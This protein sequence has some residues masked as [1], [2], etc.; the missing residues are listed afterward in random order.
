MAVYA[1]QVD[2][3][4]Q[5][6][7]RILA[8]VKAHGRY[9]NTLV[10]FLSDNGGCAE[11]LAEDGFV[12]ELLWPMRD[13][14]PV[15]AGNFQGVMPGGEDTYMSYD[16]PWANASNTPFRLFKHW[17]HEGGIATPMIASWPR[18]MPAERGRLFHGP[19]HVIDIMSTCIDA[20]GIPFPAEHRGKKTQPPEGESLLPVLSGEAWRRQTPLFWEHEGNCAIRADEWKL[21][22][23][24]PGDW[25]LYNVWEDRTELRDLRGKNRSLVAELEKQWNAWAERC[26]VLAWERIAHRLRL[27]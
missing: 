7:G 23:K 12:Q 17:V 5:G 14:Q 26:R 18:Q 1:A 25:E 16:L 4:D 8:A 13:G 6:V 15:R 21:V 10:L 11:Y 3:M 20:A 24:Y 22:R 9:D 27:L 2:R 19:A